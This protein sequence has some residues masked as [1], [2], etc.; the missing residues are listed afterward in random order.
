MNLTPVD[1]AF[2]LIAWLIA[3]IEVIAALYVL[4]LNAWH[5]SNRH[6]SVFLSLSAV[7]T[8][9]LGVM[10]G[11]A[12]VGQAAVPTYL[13]AAAAPASGP[14][15]FLLSL[16]LLKPDRLRGQP[17]RPWIWWGIFGV[18]F[19]PALLVPVDACL[20][21]RLWYTG[22]EAE[23]Y[24]GGFVPLSTF[25]AG[26]LAPLIQGLNMRVVPILAILPPL[27]V[28]LLD[29]KARPSTRR[30]ARLLLGA[31]VIIITIQFGLRILLSGGAATLVISTLSALLYTYVAIQQ[32]TSERRTQRGKLQP[33]LT[34]VVL[35]FTVPLL[36]AVVAFVTARA[37]M[38]I[39]K[40][41]LER[42]TATNRALVSSTSVWLDLNAKALQELASQPDIV[43]MEPD[44]QKP[45]L[46]AMAAAYPHMYLVSTTDWS[47]LNVARSDALPPQD[48]HGELW[49]TS[50]RNGVPLTY[51]V[52][53]DQATGQ[54]AL[55]ASVPIRR[56]SG[57]F[58]GIVGVA[59]FA[60]SLTDITQEVQTSKPGETG[61][62]Y[63]VDAHNRVVAHTD[64][65]LSA[66]LQDFD[67]YPPVFA[68]RGGTQGSITFTDDKG[69]RW[70]AYVDEMDNGWGIV[71]Q[72]REDELME[73]LRV[74][75]RISWV[76]SAISAL[77]LGTIASLTI[78]QAIRPIGTLTEAATAIAGGDLSHVAPVESEDEIG[79]LA[80]A[81]NSMTAQLRELIGSLE[82]RVADQTRD[83]EQRAIQLEA[84]AQV[85]QRAAAI[86]DVEQL[87]EETVHLISDRFG[88]YHAGIFLLDERGEYAVL[89]AASSHGGQRMLAR[90]HKLKV[91]EVGIV[92]HAAGT[93]KPRIALDVGAD[94]V[95]FDN[96]DL[97][98]TRS[99]MGLPLKIRDQVIGV[100]DVQSTEEKA[101]SDEDVAILQTMADQIAIAIENARLLEETQR[102]LQELQMAYRRYT[103]ESWQEITRHSGRPLGYR[104]RRMG[105]EPA[106]E[107][108]PEARQAWREGH[109][110]V[111]DEQ[112]EEAK[113][114]GRR[115]GH[116]VRAIGADIDRAS[117]AFRNGDVHEHNTIS[118]LAVPMKL[119]D[120]IVGVLNLRFEGEL[121]S[122]DTVSLIE[123]IANRLALA[124][125]NARLLEETHERAE[126]ERITADISAQI[127]ASMDPETILQTAVRG[128]GAALGTDRA[129]V[130]LAVDKRSTDSS[131]I[132]P[133]ARTDARSMSATSAASVEE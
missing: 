87:L 97:P 122:P 94:A 31:D 109:P 58:S 43:S 45:F 86:R 84:A 6:V 110:V 101:F 132:D 78:R 34:A 5:T 130:Q 96:P 67:T 56:V 16:A 71:V 127:R 74:F 40:N 65:T 24:G 72:Q 33:R 41:A 63:I 106:V 91:G 55:V 37:G 2:Q 14:W 68:L 35:T 9:A 36:V 46:E 111:I 39:E 131:D 11:A 1:Q 125:E 85:A 51:E 66:Q 92:G 89:Q 93:G 3:L 21:T 59:M 62:A 47:G 95:F 102:A 52:F 82:Q 77:L 53:V 124:L 121:A 44:R 54:P 15:L 76:A 48:Y 107:Q 26:T 113:D 114:N 103:Q 100:L 120:Q 60:S 8:F 17:R 38:L 69:Q 61:S 123:E 105:I 64:P 18:G 116:T 98:N 115:D 25:A 73:P 4:V 49:H 117:M 108:S 70:R 57:R 133:D 30:L 75:R 22:L 32:M 119:R 19:L 129:F 80:S 12:D 104:Y 29:K 23:T 7:S 99:E 27:Y 79:V 90:E 50:A 118:G 13:M 128:L 42:L 28:A 20:G 83:L 10:K 81:F 112:L 126:R 88:F